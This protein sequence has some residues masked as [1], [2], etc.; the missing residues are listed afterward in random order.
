VRRAL[1]RLT[2]AAITKVYNPKEENMKRTIAA[3][4]IAIMG[5]LFQ[6]LVSHGSAQPDRLFVAKIPFNFT[7]CR[8]E[9]PAGKYTVFRASS[10]GL[11]LAIRNEDG[12]SMDLA[13]T[14]DVKS[15]KV[16]T[17]GKLVFN[18]YDDQYFL[19]EVWW[20]GVITGYELVKTDR[21]RALI[22]E[23]SIGQSKPAKKMGKVTIKLVNK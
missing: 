15:P 1:L 16:V 5:L 20:S 3:F 13:C 12:R 21:E 17:E 7:V 23:L 2:P 11:V 9:L 10:S 14:Q 18:R 4:G 6:V 22:K 19:S 8:E